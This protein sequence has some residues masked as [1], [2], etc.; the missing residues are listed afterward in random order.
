MRG[1]EQMV[2]GDSGRF[3]YSSILDPRRSRAKEAK[4]FFTPAASRGAVN[5]C[6]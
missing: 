6:K 2:G 4:L 3:D 1:G 5:P